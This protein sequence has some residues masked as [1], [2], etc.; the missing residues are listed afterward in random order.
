MCFQL[1]PFAL[2]VPY[3][4][5]QLVPQRHIIKQGPALWPGSVTAP[6]AQPLLMYKIACQACRAG[7]L[8]SCSCMVRVAGAFPRPAS[9]LMTSATHCHT[10]VPSA[11]Q[12]A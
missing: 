11:A 8:L 9:M 3:S 6:D 7:S 1:I 2:E 12:A 4:N 10:V 5:A